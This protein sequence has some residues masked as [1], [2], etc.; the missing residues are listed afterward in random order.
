M[1]RFWEKNSILCSEEL[2][3]IYHLPDARYNKIPTIKWLDY[4]V[5]PPPINLPE[6]GIVLGNSV[7][8]GQSKPVRFLRNDRTRHTYVVGKS[9]SGKS[10]LL[11]NMAVQDIQNGEGT[12]VIDPHGDLIEDCLQ[13]VPKERAKNVIVFDPGD[14][15]RPMGLNLSLIHI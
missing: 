10:V 5:L 8:R 1:D 15:Q 14:T 4:K 13:C 11:W 9:G 12:C 3:T 7:Y 2:A 6:E